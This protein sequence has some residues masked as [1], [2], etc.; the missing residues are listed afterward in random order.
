LIELGGL[1]PLFGLF[2]GRAKVKGP[3]GAGGGK[4]PADAA[5]EVEERTVSLISSLLQHA[6]RAGARARVAAK[7]VE[8]EYE[9]ADMLC[10]LLFRYEDGVAAAEAR[11]APRYEAGELDEADVAAEQLDA[12]LFTLQ[13]WPSLMLLWLVWCFCCCQ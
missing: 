5:R 8:A 11:L 6:P 12:G 9:K 13:V 4:A 3:K 10:E 1:S 7:F 2:M